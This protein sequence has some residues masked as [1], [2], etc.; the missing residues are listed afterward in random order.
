MNNAALWLLLAATCVAGSA[1]SA[2]RRQDENLR[3]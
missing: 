2:E 3:E 1:V